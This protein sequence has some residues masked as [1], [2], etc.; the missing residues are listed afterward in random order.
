MTPFKAKWGSG[1]MRHGVL[2][3]FCMLLVACATHQPRLQTSGASNGG[4]PGSGHDNVIWT[5][6]LQFVALKAVPAKAPT[7]DQPNSVPADRLRTLL[8][9]L[10]V[11]WGTHSVQPVFTPS[12]LG[13]LDPA[14]SKALSEARPHQDVVFAVVTQGRPPNTGML[15]IH[16]RQPLMTTGL[17]YYRNG[18]LNIIFGKMHTPFEAR[19]INTGT[20]PQLTPGSRK[21]RV[22]SGWAVVGGK[23]MT[24]PRPN[25]PDWVRFAINTSKTAELPVTPPMPMPK[26]AANNGQPT[27]LRTEGSA[28][29]QS[30]AG[31]LRILKKLHANGLITGKEYRQKRQ[32]IL[33][34]L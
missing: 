19:Y 12:A 33:N 9:S 25:R 18:R 15:L 34:N 32:E 22:Q 28:T 17:V 23:Q 26:R 30:I 5:S 4:A 10:K 21:Q 27:Q 16:G 24:H 1:A 2:F 7:N 31:R 20:P 11:K 6:G 13:K 14:L 3:L 8:G 29:Y